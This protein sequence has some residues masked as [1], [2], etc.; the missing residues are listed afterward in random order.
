[1]HCANNHRFNNGYLVNN[2][3]YSR[4]NLKLISSAA[5]AGASMSN[6]IFCN[7]LKEKATKHVLRQTSLVCVGAYCRKYV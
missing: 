1:M 4:K 2:K 7:N 6:S 5:C 3:M